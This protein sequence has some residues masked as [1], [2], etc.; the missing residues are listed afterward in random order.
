MCL[1]RH[2][3]TGTWYLSHMAGCRLKQMGY[4]YFSSSQ[5][6]AQLSGSVSRKRTWTVNSHG[7]WF[8][9]PTAAQ[10]SLEFISRKKQSPRRPGL[11]EENESVRFCL[12]SPQWHLHLQPRHP[13]QSPSVSKAW[14]DSPDLLRESPKSQGW[15]PRPLGICFSASPQPSGLINCP[16]PPAPT[17]RY[18]RHAQ[19]F[20]ILMNVLYLILYRQG[21]YLVYLCR[22]SENPQ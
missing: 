14:L 13:A 22:W 5:R 4:L 7:P 16:D 6:R 15:Q 9:N 8:R 1:G 11:G 20:L 12:T 2:E 10:S 19:L 21:C 18:Y 3:E 17:C